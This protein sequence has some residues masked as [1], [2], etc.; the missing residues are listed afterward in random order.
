MLEEGYM[1]L[2]GDPPIFNTGDTEDQYLEE[3]AVSLWRREVP[4]SLPTPTSSSSTE[5]LPQKA[6]PLPPPHC[7]Q[8]NF[9][10]DTGNLILP[11]PPPAMAL[12][13]NGFKVKVDSVP[14]PHSQRT[15]GK[16]QSRPEQRSEHK[17]IQPLS[18]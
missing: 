6:G 11:P 17:D 18:L 12:Q 16:Q 3:E 14:C 15:W 5:Q 10:D 4:Y 1:V 7:C 2:S 13:E 8:D 9:G